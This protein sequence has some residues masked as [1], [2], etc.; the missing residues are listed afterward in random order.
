LPSGAV[1]RLVIAPTNLQR[2]FINLGTDR[3]RLVD[4]EAWGSA[5]W[6]SMESAFYGCNNLSISA[7]DIPNLSGVSN[8]YIMFASCSL[9][10]GP[11][12]INNW[13][14][15]AITNMSFMFYFASS[16]NQNINSWNTTNVSNM[17]GMFNFASTFNQ[18]I[19]DWNTAAA[20][21][22]SSMFSSATSFNQDI[23]S[24]NTSA[25]T[26]MSGLFFRCKFL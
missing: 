21:N 13:N 9:L 7:T 19:G 20:I 4:V 6:T 14:T 10:N 22:M 26:N 25:V 17:S 16:F 12:N 1:V 18:D 11:T 15:S 5:N 24:W 23:G 8:C 2:F 3:S